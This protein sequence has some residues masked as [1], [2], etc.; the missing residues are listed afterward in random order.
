MRIAFL[1]I[2]F[3]LGLAACNPKLPEPDSPGAVL[4]AQRCSGCHR[5]YA[6]ASMKFEL[7][8]FQVERMQGEMARRGVEPLNDRD[9]PIVLDYLKRHAG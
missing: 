4:Y 2:A 3:V 5:L 6:P 1:P 7:W 9:L 8:K